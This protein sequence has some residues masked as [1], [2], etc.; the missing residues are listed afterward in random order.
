LDGPPDAEYPTI[1]PCDYEFERLWLGKAGEFYFG[2]PDEKDIGHFKP[3]IDA[4]KSLPVR[5]ITMTSRSLGS[6]VL[7]YDR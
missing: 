3:V 1:M 4:L 6:M 5:E 7:H 2:N